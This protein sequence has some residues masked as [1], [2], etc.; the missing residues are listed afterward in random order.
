M[1][2]GPHSRING[3]SLKVAAGLVA[4]AACDSGEMTG[5][6][7]GLPASVAVAPDSAVLTY[8]GE[9]AQFTARVTDGTG[10]AVGDAVRWE[11]TDRAVVTV[12]GS[13]LVTARGNGTAE[14]RASLGDVSDAAAVRVEQGAT[15]LQTFGDGQRALAGRSLPASVGVQVQDVGARPVAGTVVRFAVTA[16]GGSV[17]RDSVRSDNS[18]VASAVWTVGSTLGEQRLVASVAGG[19]EAEF[20][21]RA[22]TPDSAVAAVALRSG[23][24]EVAGLGRTVEVAV[25]VADGA[26]RSVPGA[27]IRFSPESAGDSVEPDTVRSDSSGLASTSWTLGLAPGDHTL[28]VAAGGARLAVTATALD[29]AVAVAT[30]ELQSGSVERAAAGQLL[31]VEVRVRDEDG[32]PVA[33]GLVTFAAGPSGGSATPDST[34]SDEDGLASSAWRLGLTTGA[35]YTLVVT[36]GDSR[37]ELTATAVD[38]NLAVARVVPWSG[39]GQQGLV[40]QRLPEPLV[41]QA[42]DEAGRPVPGALVSFTPEPGAGSVEPESARSD[43]A[44]LARAEWRL[45]AAPGEQTLAVSAAGQALLEVT[46]TARPDAGVCGRTPAVIAEL[47]GETGVASCAD[48]TDAHLASVRHLFL[49]DKNIS[50]LRSGDFADLTSLVWLFL[51]ENDLRALPPDVFSGLDSLYWLNLVGNQLEALPPGTLASLPGLT[52]LELGRNRLTEIRSHLVGLTGLEELDLSSNPLTDVPLDLLAGMER[53][54]RLFLYDVGLD[55]LPSGTFAGLSE[56]TFLNVSGNR[57]RRLP[58]EIFSDLASLEYLSLV[59]NQ[60][61]ELPPGVF[62]RLGEL[63][64]IYLQENEL[65]GLDAS[66]FAGLPN[67]EV[68]HLYDNNLTELPPA[69][70]SGL[71]SLG[72]L[73]LDANRIPELPA[74]LFAGVPR[75]G[76]LDLSRNGL[77]TL[78][79]GIFGGLGELATLKLEQNALS[80]LP[81]GIFGGLGALEMLS[82][83]VN[84]LSTLPQGVFQGLGSLAGL[85]LVDNELKA[86]PRGVFSGLSSLERL[87]LRVNPGAPFPVKLELGRTDAADALAPGPASVVLRVPSGV[88]H[89]VEMPVTVQGGTISGERVTVAAGDTVSAVLTVSRAGTAGPVHVGLGLPPAFPIGVRG[90]EYVVGEE[91]VLFAPAVN[92]SPT[93]TG[94]VPV[95]WLQAGVATAEVEMAGHFRDPDG[96]S[97]SFLAVSS[98]PVVVAGRVEGGVLELEPLAE[99][100][101][102]VEVTAR[103]PGGLRATLVIPVTVARAPDPDGY[104]IDLIFWEGTIEA[105]RF[106]EAEKASLRRAAARWEEVVTG[107]L[108]DVPADVEYC[109]DPGRIVG[110]IDDV[111]IN[112]SISDA[113]RIN[114]IGQAGRCAIRESG[115]ALMGILWLNRNY[116]G[117]DAPETGPNSMYEVAL[118]E[119]GHVLGI[120]SNKWDD[121]LREKTRDRD[122]PLDTHFP[123]P[124]AVEA[125]NEAGGRPYA[126]GKV[127]VDNGVSS[128]GLN[129]HWRYDVLRGELMGPRGGS[130]LSA[131]TVQALADLGYA[132]DVSRA[133]PY[134]LPAA[135]AAPA[136]DVAGAEAE[137]PFA[138]DVLKGPLVVVD[139]N[140]NVVRIIRN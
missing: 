109:L 87:D 31:P 88:L 48:V 92:R 123:G 107:D 51:Y 19:P 52:R 94:A 24:G 27:L 80:E 81:P 64:R 127:P 114:S 117:P 23:G 44:G 38:P 39:D 29:P 119:M 73:R 83:Q 69:L 86:L 41:V 98:D 40:G 134:E 138:G 57:L 7:P 84:R 104:Q 18:G 58:A 97:L 6:V 56:L 62:A 115:L 33:G 108:P 131:I 35:A 50:S 2:S 74:H 54:Q 90:L 11:S 124:L 13:G 122:V 100:S 42:L 53:L 22:V 26:G 30:V 61:A 133:D 68:L 118:H 113:G 110:K 59:R 137:S 75:L 37:L 55:E 21:A 136:A 3:G 15:A 102:A 47:L 8:L 126:G 79:A 95:H 128:G 78:P 91:M 32:R 28:A 12:D 67:L 139:E 103:D 135:D 82:L 116:Y 89:S 132:V 96:D 34:L 16:G 25:S 77:A 10:A 106:T 1:K 43:S 66:V 129:N 71:S 130:A 120:G 46:A 111:V 140:G 99:G 49:D 76:S 105:E 36:S 93:V 72:H 121:M 17:D 125:F 63:R 85:A 20:T 14:V 65:T 101:A 5:P 112:V 45:G 4:I 9:T 60:L 70:F